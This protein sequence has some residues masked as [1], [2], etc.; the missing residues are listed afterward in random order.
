MD[1]ANIGV[2]LLIATMVISLG[3]PTGPALNPARDLGPRIVHA[4]IPLSNKGSSHWEYSWVPVLG[5]IV[6][7]I[8][9]ILLYKVFFGL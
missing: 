2:G 1:L 5:S 7:A 3:G 4:L 9:G 8:I 6:G